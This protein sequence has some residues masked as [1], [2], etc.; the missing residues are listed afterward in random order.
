MNK[1]LYLLRG[2]PGS[3]KSFTANLLSENGKYPVLSADM[4]FEDEEG[5]YNWDASKIKEAHAWCKNEVERFMDEFSIPYI[6]ECGLNSWLNPAVKIFVANTFTQDWEMDDY[7][8]LAEKYGYDVVSL[9]VENRHGGVSV[10]DVPP[11]T[12][13]KMKER[14]SIKL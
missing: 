2:L 3:G 10:H 14:F 8:S 1:T 7:F 4:F 11:A 5:N 6:T 13:E 9:I 12:I